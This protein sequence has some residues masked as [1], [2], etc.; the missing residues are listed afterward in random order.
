MSLTKKI[1]FT[2][3]TFQGRKRINNFETKFSS[4]NAFAEINKNVLIDLENEKYEIKNYT[5]NLYWFNLDS[6]FAKYK[7]SG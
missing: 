2:K 5:C 6:T 1:V 7:D 3:L 4:L